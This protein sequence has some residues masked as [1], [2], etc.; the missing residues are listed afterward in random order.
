MRSNEG[1]M[2]QA[3]VGA[4]Q[5][6]GWQVELRQAITKPEDL[7]AVLGLDPALIPAARRA[8]EIFGLRV[9][10]AFV[11]R[12]RRGDPT[13]PLLRQVL[14]LDQELKVVAGYRHDPVGDLAAAMGTG[15][16]QKYQG[17]VLLITTG[18][19][20]VHCRYCFHRHFPYSQETASIGRWH[21]ALET[22][23]ADETI[24]E[25]I[26]SGGD[27]LSLGDSKLAELVSALDGIPQLKRLRLHTRQPIVLPSRV[28][29]R[30]LAWLSATRLDTVVVVHANHPA[31]IDNE[32]V[33]ALRRLA[34]S[35]A[36]ML[37][38][39]VLLAGVNDDVEVLAGL[40]EALFSAGV[41]PYYL[42]Q[43]DPVIGAAHFEVS[44]ERARELHD[45]LSSRLPGYLVP[46]L[47]RE[48]PG[49]EA[50]LLLGHPA[51]QR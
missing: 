36:W 42:H 35:G 45:R 28:D 7:I 16:L 18:A 11:S 44:D 30:L 1:L 15:V 27:P 10:R 5:R 17:R 32:V 33:K 29:R 14:P 41:L 43:L 37:N 22:I 25:V 8:A 31:E 9:P 23:S 6:V 34:G 26:L 49:A 46:R 4:E 20:A 21:A 51:A 2:I 39:S 38:Q 19:C 50:K 40:S 47:V 13:D 48:V 24:E 12:M 3:A